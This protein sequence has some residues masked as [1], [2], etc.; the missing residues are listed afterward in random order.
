MRKRRERV[1]V[2]LVTAALIFTAAP[3]A[4]WAEPQETTKVQ[5]PEESE[6]VM[7]SE[8]VTDESADLEEGQDSKEADL[9]EGQDSKEVEES[10]EETSEEPEAAEILQDEEGTAD[11]TDS[12]EGQDEILQSMD[13][14]PDI[15]EEESVEDQIIVVYEDPGQDNVENLDLGVSDVVQGESLCET[16]DLL[17]MEESV[18]TDQVIEELEAKPGVAAVSRNEMIELYELPNDP[19][20]KGGQAWQFQAMEAESVWNQISGR[21][22]I[23]VAVIDSGIDM[24]HPDLKGRCEIGYD[25]VDN[26]E[27]SMKDMIGHGTAVSGLIAAVA[28]NGIG[29]AGIAGSAPVKVVAYRAGGRSAGENMLNGAYVIA[30]ME[31]IA[32]RNDIQVVNMSFGSETLRDVKQEAVRKLRASGK[33]VVAAAGNDGSTRHNYPASC[34]GV[35]S[36]G[37]VCKDYSAAVFSNRNSEVDL[38]APGNQLYTTTKEG[39]YTWVSGTSY[40][41]PLVA[42]AA[43]VLKYANNSLSADQIE[44]TL[45]STARDLGPAGRDDAYGYGMVRL[46]E[47]VEKMGEIS[48]QVSYQSHVQSI[49]WQN[50]KHDGEMSG[51]EGNALRLEGIKINISG[52]K[53]LGISYRSHVQGYGWQEYMNDGALS[54]TSGEAK[55]LEAI[56]IRL[57]GAEADKYDVYYRTHAQTYGWLDWAKNG[58]PAGTE[59]LGKRL[60]A[61]QIIVVKKGAAAPGKTDAPFASLYTTGIVRYRTH[62]QTE[63]WQTYTCD[64]NTSGTT[65]R[66]RRLEG[67]NLSL[68]PMIAGGIQ[69]RSHIQKTGWEDNFKSNGEMSGTSGRS[70][71]LEAVQIKLTG[72]AE[73]RY[74]IYYRV[75]CQKFGWLGWAKNGESAGSSGYAYRLE[76]IE[77]QLV[78]KGGAAPGSVENAYYAK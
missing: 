20:I 73:K 34:A 71:R 67:I 32:T 59:G 41:S 13:Q 16:V 65:G 24:N 35:I 63:G 12:E 75:H 37:A 31:R 57:T 48:P 60:E 50:I 1:V 8:D 77:V 22:E 14:V 62:V 58:I 43:A 30:A 5:A 52:S 39:G 18:D 28:N 47:V 23:K 42:G 70:L 17:E 7:K 66:S 9:E 61:I 46:G 51:T 33:V 72:E 21:K 78:E 19:Y 25:Y 38:C 56:Q 11:I 54:G 29:I 68:S 44:A 69:Y 49:G 40:A 55:R 3:A 26:T 4:V 2:M 53:D 64:G 6:D 74:D 15:N 45:K 10:E 76:A 27:N 36:V